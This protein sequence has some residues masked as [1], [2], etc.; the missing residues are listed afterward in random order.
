MN[1]VCLTTPLSS[2]NTF[3]G[4]KMARPLPRKHFGNLSKWNFPSCLFFIPNIFRSNLQH[5]VIK[6]PPESLK[7]SSHRRQCCS[8][9]RRRCSRFRFFNKGAL[10]IIRDIIM[11][12]FCCL[13]C[14]FFYCVTLFWSHVRSPE[15]MQQQQNVKHSFKKN[16]VRHLSNLTVNI[17]NDNINHG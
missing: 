15:P 10:K 2:K 9:F 13:I 12:V 8:R 6:M 14:N 7:R 3:H 5:T 17:N 1:L 16:Q 4:K 11:S